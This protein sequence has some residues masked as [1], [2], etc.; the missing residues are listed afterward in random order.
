MALPAVHRS[1]TEPIAMSE[2]YSSYPLAE[3][4]T[5]NRRIDRRY[6][7]GKKEDGAKAALIS[8]VQEVQMVDHSTG[9]WE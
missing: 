9:K 5:D 8:E 1:P 6:R 4:S 3:Y 2:S 7:L